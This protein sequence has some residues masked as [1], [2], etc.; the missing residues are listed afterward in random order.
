MVGLSKAN[1]QSRINFADIQSSETEISHARPVLPRENPAHPRNFVAGALAN[2]TGHD[3]VARAS[4][5]WA[6]VL[7]ADDSGDSESGLG[8]PRPPAGQDEE[9]F[10]I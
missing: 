7:S 2:P 5:S 4:S 10:R 9:F 6:G 3:R 1:V 8:L